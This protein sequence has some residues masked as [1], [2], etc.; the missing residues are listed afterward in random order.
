LTAGANASS[1]HCSPNGKWLVYQ[2]WGSSG[3][4]L[5]KLSID[6]GEAL[7]VTDKFGTLPAVSPNGKLIGYYYGDP[8]TRATKLALLPFE[9]GDHVKF[10]DLPTNVIAPGEIFRQPVRWT[11]DGRGLTYVITRG[12]VSNIWLQPVNGGSHGS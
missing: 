6:G 10:F 9:G 5:W 4:S 2:S 12:L 11:P 3:F 7:L 8:Q 1:P